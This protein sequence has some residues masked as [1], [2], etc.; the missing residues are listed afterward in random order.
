MATRYRQGNL[1]ISVPKSRLKMASRSSI[2]SASYVLNASISLPVV[3]TVEDVADVSVNGK[4]KFFFKINLK[5]FL[6]TLSMTVS[7]LVQFK[8]K[9]S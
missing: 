7:R 5:G 3:I 1:D 4:P 6:T 8:A 2:F 9:Y